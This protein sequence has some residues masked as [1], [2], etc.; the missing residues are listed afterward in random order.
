MR[1]G[2]RVPRLASLVVAFLA[3]AP[4]AHAGGRGI[5][6]VYVRVGGLSE[7][8]QH[9]F[10]HGLELGAGGEVIAR[11]WLVFGLGVGLARQRSQLG[12]DRYDATAFSLEGHGRWLVGSARVR[13]MLEMGAG[14]YRFELDVLD[15]AGF[16][17]QARWHAPG[18]WFG[19]GADVG[20][21]ESLSV[22]PGIAYHFIAQST[23]LEGGNGE[24]YFA[25]GI[26]LAYGF[27]HR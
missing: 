27:G 14:Y 21:N 17:H 13:P 23:A 19:L 16:G 10:K 20:I 24:D 22:R 11:D 26:T 1:H 12:Y 15:D 5:D 25:A 7:G 9:T 4:V 2:T 3:V 6:A 8:P 18:L